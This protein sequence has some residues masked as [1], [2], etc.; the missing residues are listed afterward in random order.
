MSPDLPWQWGSIW[1]ETGRS[2]RWR[3]S[4]P[5]WCWSDRRRDRSRSSWR[6]RPLEGTRLRVSTTTSQFLSQ[7]AAL[8]YWR[9]PAWRSHRY[10]R[11]AGRRRWSHPW[12]GIHHPGNNATKQKAVSAVPRGWEG[13]SASC[14]RAITSTEEA[15]MA[16]ALAFSASSYVGSEVA[17]L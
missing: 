17:T 7:P 16:A 10:P 5:Q 9:R 1:W 15:A 2:H 8:T 11:G 14:T 4:A 13:R 12:W 6:G 3:H